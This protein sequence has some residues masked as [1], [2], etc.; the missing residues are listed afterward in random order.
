MLCY[1]HIFAPLKESS[2]ADLT[3]FDENKDLVF[4]C[5]VLLHSGAATETTGVDCKCCAVPS[6]SLCHYCSPCFSRL[7][8]G[9]SGKTSTNRIWSHAME[10]MWYK[11]STTGVYNKHFYVASGV[12]GTC[13]PGGANNKWGIARIAVIA[14]ECSHFLG[15]PDL[16]NPDGNG[17]AGSYDILA[18]M[19]GWKGNQ[20]S[21]QNGGEFSHSHFSRVRSFGFSP[22]PLTCLVSWQYYP[23]L[24]SAYSKYKMQ[25]V[26]VVHVMDSGSY[27]LIESS[28]SNMVYMIDHNMPN[29][30]YFLVEN[31][32]LS[33]FDSELWHFSRGKSKHCMGAALWHVNES[34][35]LGVDAKNK[36]IIDFRMPGYPGDG[37][38]PAVHYIAALV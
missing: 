38:F 2:G 6:S 26:K 5:L 22:S 33:S 14:H 8:A 18:N 23:P 37:I 16:Y 36:P 12:W 17:G 9:K 30:E 34:G 20:V 11:S 28:V 4:N 7:I 1:S 35:A 21:E 10:Q 13:P 3:Q 29:G 25:W 15:L 32:F 24:M 31:Q 27:P 19:W